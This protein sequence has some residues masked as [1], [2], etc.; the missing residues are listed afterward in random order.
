MTDR[1]EYFQISHVPIMQQLNPQQPNQ[2]LKVSPS[3]DLS[4]PQALEQIFQQLVKQLPMNQGEIQQSTSVPD[5]SPSQANT[6][7]STV[8]DPQQSAQQ[9]EGKSASLSSQNTTP[10][11][12]G[13]Q[14][15]YYFL[16]EQTS[17]VPPSS[18]TT[19]P[20]GTVSPSSATTPP[21]GTVPSSSTTTPPQGADQ[22]TG[23][24]PPLFSATEK[25]SEQSLQQSQ[26]HLHHAPNHQ[27][28]AIQMPD[29]AQL[30][31]LFA[32]GSHQVPQSQSQLPST[33]QESPVAAPSPYGKTPN[34][35]FL[36]QSPP[37]LPSEPTQAT[38]IPAQ[39]F[40]VERVRQDFPALHQQVNGKPLIWMDNAA[41]S[42]KP[43]MV[44]DALAQF[45]QND[46]SNVHRGA[47][48]LAARATNAY[49]E[50][51]EKIQRF[52]G[53]SLAKE[54]IYVRG[55]TE[56]INLVAQTYG[57]KEVQAGDEIIVTTLEHH[58]NIVPWQMLAQ[59]KEAVLK[60][61]PINDRG[62]VILEEYEKLFSEK[63]KIVALSHVSNVLGTVLPIKT[64]TEMAHRYGAVVLVDG[65]QS[66]P[67][68]RVNVQDLD[69][70]FFVFSGHKLFAPTGIGAVYGKAALLEAMPPWQGGGNMIDQVSFEKT[71]F[72]DI[73]Y[74]FEAGTGN[75]ADAV[76]LGVAIDYLNQIGFESA[77]HH[78]EMLL[79][80]ATQGLNTIS[81][82]RQIGTAP[83]K[84]STL[85]FVLEGVRSE[86]M[87]K[88]L[89]SEGIAVRSGHH[90]AQ[91]TLQR[92][93]LTSAVR[94]SLAFYNTC[95]EVDALIAAIEKG[96]KQLS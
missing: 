25:Q 22:L 53:A 52:L 10:I 39:G 50:A 23:A 62:E 4:N 86:D 7:G 57:R 92:Y 66:V 24:L 49:E 64:M 90:C 79:N 83:G 28:S 47:H 89:D 32:Q 61:V 12:Q 13:N 71:T 96:K 84:V 82:L 88:F 74:K 17:A 59:E 3:G 35:Y 58:S 42:Q 77:I 16:A 55:T 1:Y 27:P 29:E 6:Y 44:I 68:L 9:A 73:P 80:Y 36:P 38:Q 56:G 51:R 34:F 33:V 8:K 94:P 72:N 76:G 87:G 18:A 21:Q 31:Q 95:G 20:Q 67:H 45:Y 14:P 78:E 43:Q 15:Q 69:V 75:I 65:A 93:G 2:P 41:T 85:S 37:T 48:T 30:L 91:P 40:N 60:V 81:G 54:I 11:V 46:N 5:L 26:E 19:P 63:T 70:D